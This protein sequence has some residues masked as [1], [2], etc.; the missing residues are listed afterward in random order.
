[1]AAT[2]SLR[3]P[4]YGPT[5]LAPTRIL[6]RPGGKARPL[7]VNS[8]ATDGLPACDRCEHKRHAARGVDRWDRCRCARGEVKVRPHAPD[9]TGAAGAALTDAHPAH[10]LSWIPGGGAR[11]RWS[12]PGWGQKARPLAGSIRPLDAEWVARPPGAGVA[13]QSGWRGASLLALTMR[14]A[15]VRKY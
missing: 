2:R 5:A 12:A 6:P 8:H 7:A 14:P 3:L 15:H 11:C 4:R 1:M 10:A 13:R 9:D